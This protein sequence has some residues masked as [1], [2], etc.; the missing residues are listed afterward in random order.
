MLCTAVGL[1]CAPVIC[2]PP[3]HCGQRW[4]VSMTASFVTYCAPPLSWWPVLSDN[5]DGIS[6][7]C[8]VSYCMT[9]C[10]PGIYLRS[11]CALPRNRF[12]SALPTKRATQLPI[13]TYS[14]TQQQHRFMDL[15]ITLQRSTNTSTNSATHQRA[16]RHSFKEPPRLEQPRPFRHT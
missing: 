9:Y 8:R 2:V 11:P 14:H 4:H 1:G 6:S 16:N 3:C 7:R 5:A 12:G 13:C 10:M 15:P